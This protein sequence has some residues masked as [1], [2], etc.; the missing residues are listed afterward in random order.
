MMKIFTIALSASLILAACSSSE[1]GN[2]V[3]VCGDTSLRIVDV[4]KSD[5][6]TTCISWKWDIRE[7]RNQLPEDFQE[8]NT[9]IDDCKPVN[10]GRQILLTSSS[11]STILLDIKTRKCIFYARTPMAHSAELLPEGRIIVANS[12][13]PQGNNLSLY[14][15]K[16]PDVCIWKDSLYSGHGAVWSQKYNSLFALGF[17][18]LRR[19]TLQNWDSARP[20]LKLEQTWGLPGTSG[21]ELSPSGEDQLIVSM[22]EGVY[23][24]DCPSGEFLPFRPLEKVQNVKSVNHNPSTGRLIYTKAE[25][26]WWTNHVY[27]TNPSLTVS[28]DPDYK[29]YKV[30]VF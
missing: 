10:K 25:T 11:G 15:I 28:F 8:R 5:N 21:H 9:S 13:H 22:H 2:K 30:R 17:A 14:D 26:E 16:N 29:L 19:Y 20:F 4:A 27:F 7:A 23:L 3:I 18:E 1:W 6:D 24:F 12:T